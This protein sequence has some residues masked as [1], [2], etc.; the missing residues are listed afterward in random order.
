MNCSQ[1]YKEISE[2]SNLSTLRYSKVIGLKL[3]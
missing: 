3:S 1:H 2:Y